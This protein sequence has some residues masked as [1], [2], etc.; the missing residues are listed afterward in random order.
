MYQ[1]VGSNLGIEIILEKREHQKKG[2]VEIEDWG[3]SVH[4]VLGIQINSIYNLHLCFS[5][6]IT[7]WCKVYTKLTPGFKNHIKNLDNY[8]Q[9]VESP[10]IWNLIAYFCLKNTLVQKNTF[11]QLKHYMQRI[12]LTLFSTTCVKIHQTSYVIFETISH[13]SWHNSSVFFSS[14]ITYVLQK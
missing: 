10:K 13:F 4:F 1:F 3:F 7:K 14:N 9:A 2:C 12:Y 11:F 8:R 5:Y 6:D